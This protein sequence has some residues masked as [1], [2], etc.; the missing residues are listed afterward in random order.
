MAKGTQSK[1]QIVEKILSTF[2]GAF[3][4][5]KEIRIP[6]IEDGERVEIKVTLTCAKVNVGG[7][8]PVEGAVS[9]TPAPPA[10]AVSDVPTDEEKKNIADLMAKLGI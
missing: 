1:S 9:E 8:D 10:A 6:M 7:G 5:G 2:D 3:E 4:Y